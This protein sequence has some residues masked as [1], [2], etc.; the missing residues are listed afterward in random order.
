MRLAL[1]N[2]VQRVIASQE[3]LNKINVFPVA[4]GDTGTNMAL[5][6]GAMGQVLQVD[7][8]Q[9]LHKLLARS[10]DALLDGARG[11]SG[12]ILAQF[13]QGLSDT[14]A[15]WTRFTTDNFA[16]AVKAGSAYAR[17]ALSEPREGT[18]LSV[19]DAF[20]DSLGRH[21]KIAGI[22]FP[23]LLGEGLS[24]AEKALVLTKTQLAEL[25]K[26]DVVDAGAKGFV[27]ML[28][29]ILA[30]VRDGETIDRIDIPDDVA[31]VSM[32]GEEVDLEFRFCTE[33]IINGED[34]DR[35]KLR[36][37]LS[38]LGGSLVLAGSRY[39]AK[40]HIHVN[41]PD[42]VFRLARCYGEVSG[43]KADDMHR[44]QHTTHGNSP[45]V[46]I[47]TDSAAD[48]ADADMD[49]L[50]IHFV[51][52]RIQFGEQGYM[53]KLSI[54][55]REFFELL[56]TD[57]HHPTTSQPSPGDYRR[58]YQFLASHHK[59]V[60]AISLSSQVSGTYSAAKAAA[61]R[62]SG[63]GNIHVLDSR[64][65][66]L[67]QGLIVREAAELA[68]AGESLETIRERVEHAI[69][70]TVTFALVSD[71]TYAVR[72][73]RVPKSRKLI[74]DLLR[75]R[76]VLRT[77]PE[78]KAVADGG[79][80]GFGN[81]VEKFVRYITKRVD[82]D[83]P[84]R[85]GIGHAASVDDSIELEKQLKAALPHCI[86]SYRTDCCAAFGVH[87]GPGLIVASLLFH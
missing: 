76:P 61:Q 51:P 23:T 55:E 85:I 62:V 41:E 2:G 59:E 10:A 87:G 18:I 83:R 14:A 66:T 4:D 65:A 56:R 77:S 8:K 25:K 16:S 38:Q 63:P 34:I 48:I 12:A 72:G 39:K 53:D 3:G 74:A 40:I 86:D 28:Q 46:A 50:D 64:N 30:Y 73:G 9:P 45:R 79:I 67:G 75:I 54:S 57:S 33:C 52:L 29:G 60:L 69:D 42:A 78:G 49:A 68:M 47:I 44:Q 80:L 22:D 31:D 1:K 6:V 70:N 24:A 21:A 43:E 13:F 17:D 32:A 5:T 81:R 11:N 27:A 82:T 20:A 71:L 84:V 37:E 58:Q 26:A 7:D 35:R 36:E 19:I 15:E